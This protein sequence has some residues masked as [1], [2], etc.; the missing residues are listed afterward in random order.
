MILEKVTTYLRTR[1]SEFIVCSMRERRKSARQS[2]TEAIRILN[3]SYLKHFPL[4]QKGYR[5]YIYTLKSQ[6]FEPVTYC[7]GMLYLELSIIDA[8]SFF[9]FSF[10]TDQPTS[11][12]FHANKTSV[13][14]IAKVGGG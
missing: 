5:C 11:R 4:H 3:Q 7:R 13:Q 8:I 2:H 1:H 10:E 12:L 6:Y 9:S 14:G